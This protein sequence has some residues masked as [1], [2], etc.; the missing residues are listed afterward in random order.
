MG[1]LLRLLVGE[2]DRR[3][4][5]SDLSELHDFRRRRDGADA[6]DRW[7]RRQR[8][9]YPWVVLLDHGRA[10]LPGWTTMQHLWRDVRL[11]APQPRRR[12][13][14]VGHDRA[15]RRCR[16]GGHGG[17]RS[18]SPGR[19]SS[20]RCPTRIRNASPG[21]TP[22]TR[23]TDFPSRSSTIGRSSTT[24]R[25]SA[26]SRPIS[27]CRSRW[28]TATLPSASTAR[29]VTGSYFPLLGQQA[30]HR[31][32]LRCRRRCPRRSDRRV[33]LRLLGPALRW[34]SVGA[35]PGGD[36]RR[37]ARH[38]RRRPPADV[39]SARA[40]RRPVLARRAGR[41][42][43]ERVRSSRRCSA[44]CAPTC[45]RRL[46]QTAL[47]GHER[48]ALPDL[49]VVVPEREGD[50]GPDGSEDPRGRRRG[51]D[52]GLR[53][54]RR[55]VRPAHRLR[56]R[57]QPADRPQPAS[58]P[59]AGDSRRPW[60]DDEQAAPVRPR[61]SLR[62]HRRCRAGRPGC[63][64]AGLAGWWL[65]TARTT[66]RASTRCGSPRRPSPGWPASRRPAA[67]SSASCRRGTAPGCGS[68][69][70]CARADDRR[71]LGP[72]SRRVQRAL[73]A[74]EFALATPLLV[75][76][77]LVLTSLDRLTRVPVGIDTTHLLTASVSLPRAGYPKDAD[78]EAFWKRA[79]ERLSA[80][81]GVQSVAL[82]DSRPPSESGQQNNFDLEDRP[83]PA[84][85]NQ[86]VCPWVGVS[87]G[88]FTAAG[89]TLERGRLLDE[90]SLQEDAVVVDRAWAARFFPGQEAIGPPVPQRRLHDVPVDDRR[91]RRQRRALDRP[92][93][94]RAGRHGLLSVRGSAER[95]LPRADRRRSAGERAVGA[96]GGEGARSW[97]GAR[98]AS[99]R[100]TIWW[101][102]PWRRRAISAC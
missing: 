48:A 89:V 27:A 46:R 78:R 59:R 70:R 86:P 18:S 19:C 37:R 100:A 4:I 63:R 24:T 96:S 42:R 10:A 84:G 82:S 99:P 75:A 2:A 41:R 50:V 39:W 33:D 23:R 40:R 91:R 73:V 88:F 8:R 14:L 74:A 68:I 62:A 102:R 28:R 95:L 90:R 32:S 60:R 61:R 49:A 97:P 56:Q 13:C 31:S 15:D 30:A 35:G 80:I 29:A 45:L 51:L 85:Q 69:R 3:A 81:P 87:P 25:H 7:L 17:R 98:R 20:I 77:A 47:R 93:R 6:A 9:L 55:G 36:H 66:S 38:R 92:R 67:S 21:S 5:E 57:G 1:W 79:V 52:A 76:G 43:R 44:G 94:D 22:T 11:H 53:A 54:G 34:R 58:Q 65:S 72:T 12:P 71:P 16:A 83:T 101:P 26:P 64:G